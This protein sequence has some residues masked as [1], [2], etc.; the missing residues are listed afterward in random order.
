ME[1]RVDLWTKG[2]LGG[3]AKEQRVTFQ[4]V[5][6]PVS[7]GSKHND[8]SLLQPALSTITNIS[9][10]DKT[11]LLLN[12]PVL[13]SDRAAILF[14]FVWQSRWENC[15]MFLMFQFVVVCVCLWFVKNT[16]QICNL[17]ALHHCTE[18]C[19]CV[20]FTLGKTSI[21]AQRGNTQFPAECNSY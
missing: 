16:L 13:A 2:V 6:F 12:F 7:R 21:L 3:E 1:T 11:Y 4:S 9:G 20:C 19:L 10:F 8:L 14:G 18:C 15:A 5:C 17:P